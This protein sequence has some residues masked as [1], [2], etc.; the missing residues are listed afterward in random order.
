[1]LTFVYHVSINYNILMNI[2]NYQRLV[3][4]AKS[5]YN[6]GTYLMEDKEYDRLLAE[7]KLDIP[8]FDIF[9][10]IGYI[11]AASDDNGHHT[12]H[13][14]AF[15]KEYIESDST[16]SE[17]VL[18]GE[19]ANYFSEKMKNG[20]KWFY[21]YD[22]CSLILYY[23]P[24]TGILED[25]I[26]RSN[27][28]VG[29]RRFTNFVRLVPQKIPT[30]IRAVLCE[31]MV[32]LKFGYDFTSR[33]K[34]NGLTSSKYK[35][36]EIN[37]KCVVVACDFVPGPEVEQLDDHTWTQRTKEYPTY[38]EKYEKFKSI[39]NKSV[40]G[41][42]TFYT[43]NPL[44]ISKV[45]SYLVRETASAG[46]VT[47]V[48]EFRADGVV[49]YMDDYTEAYK[50]YYVDSAIV[51][52]EAINWY[53]SDKEQLVPNIQIEPTKIEGTDVM[54]ISTNGVSNLIQ[55]NITV[56]T[57]IKVAKV[58]MTVP[59]VI[60]VIDHMGMPDLPVCSC[61]HQFTE[62]DALGQ[63]LFCPNPDCSLKLKNRHEWFVNVTKDQLLAGIYSK[64]IDWL[65]KPINIPGFT[66]GK[67]SWTEVD[68]NLAV[69]LIEDRDYEHYLE[70]INKYY[71]FTELK[72]R[73][74]KVN[75]VPLVKVLNEILT[76]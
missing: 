35:V 53:W 25:I 34:A 20:A 14:P 27:E 51:P 45:D 54:N 32:P 21:K 44:D 36:A 46:E 40:D 57:R 24:I 38:P 22:G 43:A 66:G 59:Q 56:G 72:Y 73:I 76:K 5:Y 63:G 37:E 31:V 69:R 30:G 55:N 19:H 49:L 41:R 64:P 18:N 17:Y 28:E 71:N 8:G 70:L 2:E 1:M 50:A 4:A 65:V 48:M 16:P 47:E 9:K 12:I 15:G 3:D 74:A 29:K 7:A 13:F 39:P 23:D 26:T 68:L 58:G 67:I 33:N 52:V 10:S 62:D 75:V 11:G 60:K 6:G 61:G 42:I